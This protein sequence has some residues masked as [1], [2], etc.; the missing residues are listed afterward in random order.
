MFSQILVLDAMVAL[1]EICLALEFVEIFHLPEN[2]VS[3]PDGKR[4]EYEQKHMERFHPLTIQLNNI[5]FINRPDQLNDVRSALLQE[6][7]IGFDTEWK[8]NARHRGASIVQVCVSHR[9]END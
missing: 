6:T 7:V 8:P 4:I 5:H 3:I 2:V 1:D 9:Y